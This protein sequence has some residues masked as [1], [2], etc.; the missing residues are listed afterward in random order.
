[1]YIYDGNAQFNAAA[2]AMTPNENICCIFTIIY[3]H[4]REWIGYNI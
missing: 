4:R 3:I 2:V 1:M